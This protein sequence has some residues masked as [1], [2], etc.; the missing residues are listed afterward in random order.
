MVIGD[1]NLGVDLASGRPLA[2]RRRCR[3]SVARLVGM[4]AA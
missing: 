1:I 3:R 4:V 2:C